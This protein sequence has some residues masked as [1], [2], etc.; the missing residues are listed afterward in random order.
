MYMTD[1]KYTFAAPEKF[2]RRD[3]ITLKKGLN[4]LIA[5][6]GSGKTALLSQLSEEMKCV[7]VSFGEEDNSESGM[8][9]ILRGILMRG[10]RKAVY[11]N[12]SE[13]VQA[14]VCYH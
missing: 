9:Y 12:I 10:D 14:V 4:V 8:T 3:N 7:C 5:C 1:K 11:E 6:A 2:E 13:L